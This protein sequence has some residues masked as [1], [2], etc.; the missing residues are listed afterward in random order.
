MRVYVREMLD[1][2]LMSLLRF[3][4]RFRRSTRFRCIVAAIFSYRSFSAL[5]SRL[6]LIACTRLF[7][8]GEKSAFQ[9]RFT[10]KLF[11]A[12]SYA[13]V[14]WDVFCSRTCRSAS[15]SSFISFSLALVA[16]RSV[17]ACVRLAKD[18]R[19]EAGR[20]AFLGACH[21]L[22]TGGKAK[23]VSE[24]VRD[25]QPEF[26]HMEASGDDA[27][28]SSACL[29]LVLPPCRPGHGRG[30][31]RLLDRTFCCGRSLVRLSGER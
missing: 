17:R 1:Y 18:V 28:H 30:H 5:A 4:L 25:A 15:F 22:P 21:C 20:N 8:D 6:S 7:R 29:E 23:S 9:F 24:N 11:I 10:G 16:A 19:P 26:R 31:L 14:R 12:K 3:S 27:Y 2:E 13:L